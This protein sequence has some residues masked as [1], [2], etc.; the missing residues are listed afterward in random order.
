MRLEL[1]RLTRRA[2]EELASTKLPAGVALDGFDLRRALIVEPVP[3]HTWT[4]LLPTVAL[5]G[6]GID[7]RRLAS[8]PTI[9]LVTYTNDAGSLRSL[10]LD[11]RP[12]TKPGTASF[13][14]LRDSGGVVAQGN[15]SL[16]RG[17]ALSFDAK[18][19]SSAQRGRR[20]E[21]RGTVKPDGTVNL[22]LVPA[23]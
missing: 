6:K 9:A 16:Q 14:L 3:G 4:V 15:L 13:L 19:P 7:T 1:R 21:A 12:G 8:E 17:A 10:S 11:V 2:T 5:K 18:P 23:R 20:P 22:E